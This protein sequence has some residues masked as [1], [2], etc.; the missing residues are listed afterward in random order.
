M[1]ATF[2]KNTLNA[3]MLAH[4]RGRK[5]WIS[6]PSPVPPV[7]LLRLFS[8][9]PMSL[10]YYWLAIINRRRSPPNAARTIHDYENNQRNSCQPQQPRANT[11]KMNG[12]F[13][14]SYTGSE[15]GRTFSN[16]NPPDIRSRSFPYYQIT[17]MSIA[18]RVK[19]IRTWSTFFWVSW[20]ITIDVRGR[21]NLSSRTFYCKNTF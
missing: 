6:E 1:C 16:Q 10:A 4:A 20:L 11:A 13:I 19:I 17:I 9:R 18:Y 21:V 5:K 3:W 8:F 2:W 12:Q 7:A 15:T 14:I